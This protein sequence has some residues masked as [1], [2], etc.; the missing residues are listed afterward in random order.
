MGFTTSFIVFT[1]KAVNLYNELKAGINTTSQLNDGYELILTYELYL[2]SV[3]SACLQYG[4]NITT[5]I[6]S[7]NSNEMTMTVWSAVVPMQLFGAAILVGYVLYVRRRLHVVK[8]EVLMFLDVDV[9]TV[10]LLRHNQ[11]YQ[12]S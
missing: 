7:D 11:I 3:L 6:V 12:L 2:R 4:L 9:M 8:R 1:T 5:K 10:R